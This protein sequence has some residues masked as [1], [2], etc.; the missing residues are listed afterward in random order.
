MDGAQKEPF[1]RVKISSA[2]QQSSSNNPAHAQAIRF[3][4]GRG[5]G[6]ASHRPLIDQLLEDA[7]LR[8][9]G[10]ILRGLKQSLEEEKKEYLRLQEDVFTSFAEHE[11][12]EASFDRQFEAKQSFS[13]RVADA[14]AEV[15]GS[16]RFVGFFAGFM[17]LWVV[18][19]ILSGPSA[20]DPYPFILLNLCLSC[21]S[22]FQAPVIMMSQNRQVLRDRGQS[23]YT[24]RVN[25][26]AELV[27]RHINAKLDALITS[28]WKRLFESQA[29][30]TSLLER[31]MDME[32]QQL[33]LRKAAHFSHAGGRSKGKIEDPT[34]ED[35]P[36]PLQ[37]RPSQEVVE[38][39]LQ[40]GALLEVY[41]QGEGSEGFERGSVMENGKD[42][43][44]E[45]GLVTK[46]AVQQGQV[47]DTGA[48]ASPVSPSSLYKTPLVALSLAPPAAPA[49]LALELP[50]LLETEEDEHTLYLMRTMLRA[51]RAQGPE[52]QRDWDECMVFEH[53]SSKLGDNFMGIV[54]HVRL[55]S[56]DP[57]LASKGVICRAE[58]ADLQPGRRVSDRFVTAAV[59]IAS[60]V[61]TGGGAEA[62]FPFDLCYDLHFTDGAVLDSILA[63]D[64]I[65]TLR[66]AL[67]LPCMTAE[68]EII[69]MVLHPRGCPCSLLE[70]EADVQDGM[71]QQ[72]TSGRNTRVAVAGEPDGGISGRERRAETLLKL[73]SACPQAVLVSQG[74]V[75]PRF[76]PSLSKDREDRI[77]QFW[78]RPL[79]R[80]TISYNPAPIFACVTLRAG[81]MSV[82]RS[83][84]FLTHR[85]DNSPATATAALESSAAPTA[86][87][88][89]A[90]PGSGMST[91]IVPK[92]GA[93]TSIAGIAASDADSGNGKSIKHP[94]RRANSGGARTMA[95]F[96]GLPP[97]GSTG[98]NLSRTSLPLDS[99]GKALPPP[100]HPTMTTSQSISGDRLTLTHQ[101]SGHLS[102]QRILS[103]SR[104]S[105]PERWQSGMKQEA[106]GLSESSNVSHTPKQLYCIVNPSAELLCNALAWGFAQEEEESLGGSEVRGH[107]HHEGRTVAGRIS[108]NKKE[109]P[110]RLDPLWEGPLPHNQWV[111]L[112]LREQGNRYEIDLLVP[113]VGPAA[114]F[115][116]SPQGRLRLR[117]FLR[118]NGGA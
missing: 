24:A 62:W 5:A 63:G 98:T 97:G 1:V 73:R 2:A 61:D 116:F 41:N 82:P 50:W 40:P 88:S 89:A 26:R 93:S 17:M 92:L 110:L 101:S 100:P 6:Q 95:A 118:D 46:I 105:L 85:I 51:K 96:F 70:A 68:G 32:Q 109:I 18:I 11:V 91:N 81:Q 78:K 115:F 29:L 23:D 60:L 28:A 103:H 20:F 117:G 36:S 8:H 44:Q 87:L 16:W 99:S 22:G 34:E 55:E 52:Q 108:K 94:L 80:V 13:G 4:G 74:E 19:N 106:S 39:L 77:S 10:E 57:S 76:K 12:M 53:R 31:L 27:T 114:V 21:M 59:E 67:D 102:L 9:H 107:L 37:R 112:P 113:V 15:G 35:I 3:R 71:Q 83:V 25:L 48:S 45:E 49:L 90:G 111:Q 38:A 7:S 56:R 47:P 58:P 65:L 79:G 30:S 42:E 75:P 104:A 84:E 64:A 33:D 54:S 72:Q 66:N 43:G 86:A 14:V 69:S